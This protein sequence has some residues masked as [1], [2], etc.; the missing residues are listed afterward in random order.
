LA[1]ER[2][3]DDQ[4]AAFAI[5]SEKALPFEL[6]G[7]TTGGIPLVIGDVTAEVIDNHELV[8]R[9]ELLDLRQQCLL[10]QTVTAARGWSLA[11]L[12]IAKAGRQSSQGL[13]RASASGTKSRAT[14]SCR[15]ASWTRLPTY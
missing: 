1:V 15:K 14:S 6:D 11:I 10:G 13:K 12:A 7:R 9:L 8:A 2:W 4:S 3:P 5:E